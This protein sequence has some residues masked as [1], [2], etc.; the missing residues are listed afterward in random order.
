MKQAL[1]TLILLALFTPAQAAP[2]GP[3]SVVVATCGESVIL[4]QDAP[5]GLDAADYVEGVI[6]MNHHGTVYP[7]AM[8][9]Q[10]AVTLANG[11]AVFRAVDWQSFSLNS[12]SITIGEG[13]VFVNGA[14]VQGLT[15]VGTVFVMD[16]RHLQMPM[17]MR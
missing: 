12:E 3:V 4:W 8:Y 16:C 14:P 9:W 6:Y 13:D 10:Y 15:Q 17:V 1:I 5:A 2:E 11:R 7:V